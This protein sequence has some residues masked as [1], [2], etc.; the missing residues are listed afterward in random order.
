LLGHRT[1]G[2][3]L[4]L[5]VH[6][7]FAQSPMPTIRVPV[8]LVS[9]PTLVFSNDN[10]FISGLE[11]KDF[12]VFDNGRRQ[13]I[14]LDTTYSS[15]TVAIAI[16]TNQDIREYLRFIQKVGSV[17]EA[18]LVGEA[19]VI[20]YAD[21]VSILKPFDGGDLAS[22][23]HSVTTAG[24]NARTLDAGWRGLTLLR[25]RQSS[26]AHLL[27]L[28]GQPQDSGSEANLKALK[29]EAETNNVTVF[30]ITLPEV[31]KAFVS[32]NL[33]LQ[34]AERG[35]F[36]ASVNLGKLISV[37]SHSTD[38]AAGRDPFSELTAATGCAQFHI[39]KQNEL[40]QAI[41]AIGID[42][43]SAYQLSYSP[44]SNEI[45]YHTV[46]VEVNVPDAKVLSRPG[47]WRTD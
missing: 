16:Q 5:A 19:A 17:F 2:S 43:R 4:G 29:D 30:A 22:A 8:R 41:A 28:I 12:R 14:A 34:A 31:G 42:A 3:I 25:Q 23:L 7:L 26:R 37:L 35:G 36:K 45:E 9:V 27:I 39:R 47:Y 24:R 6:A 21:E 18:L 1:I 15:V 33:S 38:S 10:R 32:D 20:T 44:S 13:N 11:V 40:E 46:K